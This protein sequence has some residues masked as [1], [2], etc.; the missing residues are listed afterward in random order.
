MKKSVSVILVAYNKFEHF[1]EIISAWLKQ[2]EVDDITIL[3]NS[4]K[5]KTKL[6]VLVVNVSENLGVQGK[7]SL[8]F[9]AKHDC[10]L[11]FDDDIMPQPGLVAD[12]LKYWDKDKVLSVLGRVFRPGDCYYEYQN[13]KGSKGFHAYNV[14]KPEKVDWIGAGASM[15]HRKHCAVPIRKAP[16]DGASDLWW[17]SQLRDNGVEFY[18]IPTTNWEST[19]EQKDPKRSWHLGAY[20]GGREKFQERRE[21]YAKKF[22]FL[23]PGRGK[24][25][26][27][28]KFKQKNLCIAIKS[29][30]RPDY[31]KGCLASLEANVDLKGVD[32]WLFQDGAVNPHSAIRYAEDKEIEASVMV[33]EKSK[34]PNKHV[35]RQKVNVGVGL[36]IVSQLEYLIPRYRYVAL[37]DNDLIFNKYYV[38]T[39]KTLFSQFEDD[40]EIGMIQSSY[41]CLNSKNN[42][43]SRK[44]AKKKE[45]QVAYGFGYRSEQCFWSN[46]WNRIGKCFS[47]YAKWIENCDYRELLY[48]PEVYKETRKKILADFGDIHVDFVLEKV[49]EKVN[50][51]GIHTKALRLKIVG[52]KG[53]YSFRG[54]L[55][56]Q[57]FSNV[58][59]HDIG[60]VDRYKLMMV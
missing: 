11:F 9:W 54:D 4:G 45:G 24:K 34:L 48:N 52:E 53:M 36:Q 46:K 25:E 28:R 17:E 18:V 39:L 50:Y 30:K 37:V 49:I 29:F 44:E 16:T 5:F 1:E 56:K 13:L 33:F 10:I 40:Q 31:L 15:V 7:W 2:P 51:K 23:K 8:A 22:G 57:Q 58:K 42:V 43:Q 59:L 3:D 19:P 12:F 35:Y 55:F 27:S 38:K 26:V 60:N 21:F 41:W 20:S 47:R 14:N 6:P 32:F